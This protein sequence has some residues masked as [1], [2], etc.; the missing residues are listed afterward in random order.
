MASL[1]DGLVCSREVSE[2]KV[3]GLSTD[4]LAVVSVLRLFLFHLL[5]VD[6]LS[7]SIIY[8]I[9]PLLEVWGLRGARMVHEFLGVTGFCV[10]ILCRSGSR[11]RKV[12]NYG[13]NR[14]R[15]CR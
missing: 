4:C 11:L 8:E 12:T 13:E 2:S 5:S 7:P 9:A 15:F 10:R 3:H 14:I 1:R 6:S